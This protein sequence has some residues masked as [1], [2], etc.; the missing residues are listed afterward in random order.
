VAFV[1]ANSGIDFELEG[2]GSCSEGLMHYYVLTL[3][4]ACSSATLFIH[5]IMIIFV[6]FDSNMC[7]KGT[8]GLWHV[9]AVTHACSLGSGRL[10]V[11][12]VAIN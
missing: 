4:I 10:V 7:L 12:S 5:L 9:V 1:A 6:A 8:R 11:H 2:H 3:G